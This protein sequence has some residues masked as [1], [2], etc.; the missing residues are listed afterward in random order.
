M[1]LQRLIS[2]W[3][4]SVVHS[5]ARS[6][7]V[8]ERVDELVALH[9]TRGVASM[10]EPAI[11]AFDEEAVAVFPADAVARAGVDHSRLGPVYRHGVPGRLLVPTGR[12]FV[13]FVDGEIIEQHRRELAEA[14]FAI[15]RSVAYAPQAGWVVPTAGGIGDALSGLDR[16]G[17]L[18]G[19]ENVE[20]EMLAEKESR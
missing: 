6:T 5:Y 12:V 8:Y 2:S 11:V 17:G 7:P 14:G 13:R 10:A 4:R 16:L 19:V 9:G 18:D 20:P 1:E 15:E 3:P